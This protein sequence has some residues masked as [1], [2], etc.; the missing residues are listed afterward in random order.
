MA[1]FS[2]V[3]GDFV[4]I[5]VFFVASWFLSMTMLARALRLVS[6]CSDPGPRL[7]HRARHPG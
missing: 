5:V 7:P 4:L 6:V 3:R 1:S 2:R